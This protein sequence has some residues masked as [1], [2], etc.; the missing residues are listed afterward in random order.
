MRIHHLDCATFCPRGRRMLAG[1][2]SAFGEAHLCGHVLLIEAGDALVLV[3]RGFGRQDVADPRRI[4][5]LRFLLRPRM[6]HEQTA[7]A[8][9]AARGLDPRDVRHV[10]VTH[11]DFDHAG[12]LPDFPEATVHVFKPEMEIALDPPLGERPRYIPAHFEHGPKWQPYDVDGDRWMG[13]EAVRVIEGLDPEILIVPLPGHSK[14]HSAVAVREGEHWL[15]D[16]GDA[17]FFHGEVRTPASCP[18]G[19]KV[20]QAL[21]GYDNKTRQSNRDRL[22]ELAARQGDGVRLFCSHD[23]TELQALQ[24]ERAAA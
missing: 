16:C 7:I 19:L 20:F 9:I 15:V 22:Q 5:F 14:G 23:V 4:G 8:Q 10:V 18:P 17:Y 24:R 13:F 6:R 21:N 1:E 3:D 2:G 12:G 11:L